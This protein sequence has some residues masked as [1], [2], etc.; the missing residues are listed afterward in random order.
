MPEVSIIIPAF[1]RAGSLK[2]SIPS[3]LA[4]SF[5][6]WELIVVDDCSRDDTAAVVASFQDSRIR[7]ITQ[8]QNGGAA[9]ARN[10]GV[11]AALG[12]WIAFLDS[13][14]AW[15][16]DKLAQQLPALESCPSPENTFSAHAHLIDDGG[17]MRPW[18]RRG[19]KPDEPISEYLFAANENLQT[20]TWLMHQSLVRRFPFDACQRRHED[21]GVMLRMGS[22]GVHFHWLATPLATFECHS[23]PN[24]LSDVVDA[25]YSADFLQNHSQWFTARGRA[26][27]ETRVIAR[28]LWH[29][30]ERGKA[31]SL[32]F[33]TRSI[34]ALGSREFLKFLVWLCLPSVH[35]SLVAHKEPP[36][37]ALV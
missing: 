13:D 19:P 3:V 37:T 30:G 16:P 6:D 28:Q 26:S 31:A 21:W 33:R 36:A 8:S 14:D 9:R 23:S 20:S 7:L 4:Q 17:P 2:K 29:G 5:R 1:N 15:M 12:T 22:E 10:T 27:F 18:P 25:Q 11:E 24:R 35:T 32:I 34:R